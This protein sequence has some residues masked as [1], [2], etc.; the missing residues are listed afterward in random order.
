MQQIPEGRAQGGKHAEVQHGLDR[1]VWHEIAPRNP[2]SRLPKE[3]MDMKH[4][5]TKSIKCAVCMA[6]LGSVCYISCAVCNDLQLC[7]GCYS[8]GSRLKRPVRDD[9]VGHKTSH[10]YR[11]CQKYN[12]PIFRPDWTASDELMLINGLMFYGVGNW[13]GISSQVSNAESFASCDIC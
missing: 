4:H 1:A 6:E 13:S 9:H 10:A 5:P 3:A 12:F 8:M 11:V 2:Q 7:I